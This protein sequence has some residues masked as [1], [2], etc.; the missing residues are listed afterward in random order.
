[1][2]AVVSQINVTK[3]KAIAAVTATVRTILYVLQQAAEESFLTISIAAFDQPEGLVNVGVSQSLD[4]QVNIV[5]C[6]G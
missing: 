1:M 5:L 3:E 2:S 6:R 4:F